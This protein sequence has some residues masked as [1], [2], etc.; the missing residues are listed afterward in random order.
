MTR[1]EYE[2]IAKILC[3]NCLFPIYCAHCGGL[4]EEEYGRAVCTRCKKE[5]E[6]E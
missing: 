2:K 5:A 3:P 6:F 1:E 4:L